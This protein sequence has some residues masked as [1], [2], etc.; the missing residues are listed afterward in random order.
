MIGS[1]SM[2]YLLSLLGLPFTFLSRPHPALSYLHKVS[3]MPAPAETACPPRSGGTRMI[4]GLLLQ[5]SRSHRPSSSNPHFKSR[6]IHSKP[7]L[8]LLLLFCGASS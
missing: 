8:L 7:Y 3:L 6:R 4:I 5:G 2:L 1:C